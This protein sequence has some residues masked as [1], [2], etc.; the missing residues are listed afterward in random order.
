MH[1]LHKLV[2][3]RGGSGVGAVIRPVCVV[4]NG[5]QIGGWVRFREGHLWRRGETKI[6]LGARWDGGDSNDV[7]GW[8]AGFVPDIV[9]V[10]AS[11]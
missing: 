1:V 9:P 2:A 3:Y 5:R 11:S 4:R 6:N 8:G 10:S 7:D